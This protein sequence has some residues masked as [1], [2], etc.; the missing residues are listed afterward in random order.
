LSLL[1]GGSDRS[2]HFVYIASCNVIYRS[3]PPKIAIVCARFVTIILN[4]GTR[5]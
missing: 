4:M 1:I 3:T 5:P 2:R